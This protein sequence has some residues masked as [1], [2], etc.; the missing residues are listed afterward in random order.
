MVTRVV[1]EDSPRPTKKL[2]AIFF[3]DDGKRLKTVHFGGAGYM[4][5]TTYHAKNPRIAK[6][7]RLSYLRR[8]R[9]RESWRDPM[10][11]GALSRWI[12][13]EKPTVPSAIRK[14]RVLFDL[15]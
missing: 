12:L 2:V 13:W 15:K 9:V 6:Q 4:D 14:Y 3:D 5:Y 10:T 11:A 8:H 7:K 1:F